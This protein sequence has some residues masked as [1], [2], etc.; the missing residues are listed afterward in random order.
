MLL[1]G[2]LVYSSINSSGSCLMMTSQIQYLLYNTIFTVVIQIVFSLFYKDIPFHFTHRLSCE[3]KGNISA[4]PISKIMV[5][6]FVLIGL[7]EAGFIWILTIETHRWV[8]IDGETVNINTQQS[9]VFYFLLFS[10]CFKAISRFTHLSLL[11]FIIAIPFFIILIPFNHYVNPFEQID[12]FISF[13]AIFVDFILICMSSAIIE[14]IFG[15]VYMLVIKSINNR[16]NYYL[17]K[18]ER[19]MYEY[20][21]DSDNESDED[22]K[23]EQTMPYYKE[24]AVELKE[25]NLRML[26]KTVTGSMERSDSMESVLEEIAN[27]NNKNAI[28]NILG[29][30]ERTLEFYDR[31]KNIEFKNVTLEYYMIILRIILVV[32]IAAMIFLTIDSLIE[33]PIEF[34][35]VP[36]TTVVLSLFLI[37]FSYLLTF[38]KRLQMAVVILVTLLFILSL[39]V[40][41]LHDEYTLSYVA[42]YVLVCLQTNRYKVLF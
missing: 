31:N 33:D 9:F 18:E 12:R 22:N 3:Y 10:Y 39:F 42:I 16:L 17:E 35:I 25:K 28:N 20:L 7:V 40:G 34:I 15:R 23:I 41:F 38:R 6:S 4:T 13:P 5:L 29:L 36:L 21:E 1:F 32:L 2:M 8:G 26:S 19:I 30:N 37:L 24:V 11:I 14:Y 27:S